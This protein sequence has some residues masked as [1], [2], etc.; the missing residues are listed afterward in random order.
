MYSAW[1]VDALPGIAF[2]WKRCVDRIIRPPNYLPTEMN[3]VFFMDSRCPAWHSIWTEK[4]RVGCYRHANCVSTQNCN[5]TIFPT[6]ST[7]LTLVSVGTQ[8]FF[9]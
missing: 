4:L 9:S 2:G 8:I 1:V 7:H 6:L 5:L 3:K